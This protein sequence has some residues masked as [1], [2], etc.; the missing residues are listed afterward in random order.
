MADEV[1]RRR[2]V[3]ASPRRPFDR[4]GAHCFAAPRE[5]GSGTGQVGQIFIDGGDFLIIGIATKG[6]SLRA[7][8]RSVR[9]ISLERSRP[10]FG[11]SPALRARPAPCAAFPQSCWLAFSGGNIVIRNMAGF[12]SRPNG[13]GTLWLV[14][15][16]LLRYSTMARTSDFVSPAY[17]R[18]GMMVGTEVNIVQEG[19]PAAIPI[20]ACYLGWQQSLNH[21]AMLVE[22]EI[23]D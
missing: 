8:R 5:R 10:P 6:S 19:L 22:P 15:G 20:E 2:L 13:P 4:T 16:R 3:V 12:S 9:G 11:G 17:A 18:H 1:G 23:K 21:L 7:P 14:A